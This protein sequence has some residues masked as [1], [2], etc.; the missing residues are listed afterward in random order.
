VS[1]TDGFVFVCVCMCVCVCDVPRVCELRAFS[2]YVI[3]PPLLGYFL[4][5]KQRLGD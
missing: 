2:C 4:F 3:A 1:G 5:A